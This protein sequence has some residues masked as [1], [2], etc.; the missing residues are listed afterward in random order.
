[1]LEGRR[2]QI[3]AEGD[4][5]LEAVRQENARRQRA[6]NALPTIQEPVVATDK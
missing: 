5:K 2:A 1:M 3:H 4:R 6:A